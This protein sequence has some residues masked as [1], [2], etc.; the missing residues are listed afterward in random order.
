MIFLDN[1]ST[2]RVFKNVASTMSDINEQYFFNPSALYLPSTKINERIENSRKTIAERLNVTANEIFFTSCATESNTWALNSGFKNKK[3]NIIIS[4]GEHSSVYENAMAIKNKGF[5]VRIAPLDS[6]G[7]LDIEKFKTI[8]DINTNLVSIIYCSNETGAINDLKQ[9]SKIVKEVCPKAIFHSDFVQAFGKISN[10]CEN[11]GVDMCSISAH[12]IGGAKGIGALY[13]KNSIKL[14]PLLYGGGQ[15]RGFRSGTENVSGIVGFAEALKEF[16]NAYSVDKIAE[17]K[18]YMASKLI[19]IGAQINSNDCSSPC[20]LSVSVIGIK[21]EVLQ[22]M[23]SDQDVLIGLGSACASR[24]KGNRVLNT[25]GLSQKQI[26]GSIRI[27]FGCFNSIEEIK[28][29]TTILIDTVEKL[30]GRIFG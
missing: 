9:I 11:L 4:A 10:N 18:N 17:Y 19:E 30:R 7:R 26:E 8:I 14:A 5:D 16:E 24:S 27:S 22:H 21:A 2:M 20:I 28:K 3:G 12:K 15:E 13:I 29:A 25:M 23:L 6:C 1:A